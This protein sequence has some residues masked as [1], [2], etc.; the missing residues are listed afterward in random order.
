MEAVRAVFGHIRS[1]RAVDERVTR[2]VRLAMNIPDQNLYR[3]SNVEAATTI[4][5]DLRGQFVLDDDCSPVQ[6]VA[7]IDAA[8]DRTGQVGWAAAAVLRWADLS[9]VETAVACGPAV[10]PYVAGLLAFRELPVM[11]AALEQLRQPPDLLFCDGHGYAH[12]RRFGLACHL[13]V[14]T[15][16]PAIGVAKSRLVGEHEPVG[17]ERGAWQPLRDRGDV[18]GAVVRMQ[19]N[20]KPIYVSSGHRVSLLSCIELVLHCTPRFRLPEPIRAAHQAAT[21]AC[22]RAATTGSGD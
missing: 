20:V 8:W 16:L 21:A 11:L 2:S 3:P 15:G 1:A 7:G 5:L 4:Q 13:G 6:T 19:P 18:I 22:R 14:V 9:L 10:F 12:P 17:E